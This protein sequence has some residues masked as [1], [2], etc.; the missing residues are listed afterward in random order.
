MAEYQVINPAGTVVLQALVPGH[1][2]AGGAN[3]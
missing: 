2:R 3:E 1:P